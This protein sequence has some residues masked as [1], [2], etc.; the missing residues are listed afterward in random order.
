[1]MLNPYPAD[2]GYSPS[3]PPMMPQTTAAAS[4]PQPI[5]PPA[6]GCVPPV[7]LPMPHGPITSKLGVS[8]PYGPGSLMQ[9]NPVPYDEDQPTRVVGSQRRRG[10][11]PS[12]P[13][14][15]VAPT[16]GAGTKSTVTPIKD[17]DGK[18][19][20]PHCTKSYLHA[21]HLKRHLLRR[22]S[23]TG[24]RPYMCVLC[25][26]TFSRSDILKRHFQKCSVRRGHPTGVS[27][28]SHPQAHVKQHGQAEKADGLG[29]DGDMDHLNGLNNMSSGVAH[30]FGMPPVSDDMHKMTGDQNHLSRSSSASQGRNEMAPNMGVPQPYGRIFLHE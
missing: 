17:A 18:F 21:K 4:H 16:A 6:G 22:K 7:L 13:G 2:Q 20:C 10:I 3:A 30:P 12:A 25:H 26:D 24:D 28:L 29:N 23:N 1:M 11:L 15:P 9:A 27:H 8:S 19:P 14:R 5:A